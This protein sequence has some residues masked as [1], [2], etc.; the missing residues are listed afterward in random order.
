MSGVSPSQARGSSRAATRRHHA[1][2]AT[3]TGRYAHLV[4]VG[5]RVRVRAKVG[6]RIRDRVGVGVRVRVRHTV[7]LRESEGG[8][9]PASRLLGRRVARRADRVRVRPRARLKVPG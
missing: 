1:Q 7:L 3:S 4:R 2:T 5:E 8:Q 6:V 9:A